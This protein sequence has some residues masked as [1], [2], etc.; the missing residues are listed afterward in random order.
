MTPHSILFRYLDGLPISDLEVKILVDFAK[1]N[2]DNKP[3]VLYRW[4]SKNPH[5]DHTMNSFS[6]CAK[7]AK[8]V[9]TYFQ[10]TKDG[11]T[12]EVNAKPVLSTKNIADMINEFCWYKP[13]KETLLRILKKEG[14]Y[15]VLNSDIISIRII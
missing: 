13:Y 5:D 15:L 1:E 11:N 4:S 2:F 8:R 7:L 3:C 14:E 12:Y 10:K 6:S 9:G